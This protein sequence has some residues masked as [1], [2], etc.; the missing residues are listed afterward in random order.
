MI[1]FWIVNVLSFCLV[2]VTRLWFSLK[3]RKQSLRD[4]GFN[5]SHSWVSC[6][7]L[8]L[9]VNTMSLSLVLTRKKLLLFFPTFLLFPWDVAHYRVTVSKCPPKDRDKDEWPLEVMM[10]GSWSF[11]HQAFIVFTYIIHCRWFCLGIGMIYWPYLSLGKNQTSSLEMLKAWVFQ[12]TKLVSIRVSQPEH[13][14]SRRNDV[15]IRA[16]SRS[17]TRSDDLDKGVALAI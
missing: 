11:M 2:F 6:H 4:S 5:A 9:A 16:F 15:S 12:M 7:Y 8:V 14:C 1:A 3:E 17:I 13:K 10:G